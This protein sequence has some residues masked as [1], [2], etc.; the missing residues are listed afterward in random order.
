[1]RSVARPFLLVAMA[2]AILPA[3][4]AWP[5]EVAAP[6]A[7]RSITVQGQGKVEAVPDTAEVTTGITARA[8][9]AREALDAANAAMRSLMQA[10]QALKIAERDIQTSGFNVSPVYERPEPNGAARLA[11]YDASNQVTVTIRDIARLGAILDGV[12]SAGSNRV[13]GIH[14]RIAEADGLLDEA[15]GKAFA[16]ARR[17]AGIYA[18]AAGA[19]L[20]KVLRIVEQGARLPRPR[21]Y[22]AEAMDASRA[23]PVAP[24]TQE[25]AVTINV[26]F[27]LE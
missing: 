1:M 27:A 16:D 20:G 26:E 17:R 4:G 15:R 3:G 18:K 5:A 11:G 8:K 23:V 19:T 13:H 14:F 9:S 25:L 2:A 12:V 24:G 22:A 7:P 21:M 10:L 6:A